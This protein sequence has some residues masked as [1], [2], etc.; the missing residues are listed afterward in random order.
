MKQK[1]PKIP[2]RYR[3]VLLA[4]L[5]GFVLVSGLYFVTWKMGQDDYCYTTHSTTSK[6]P[7]KLETAQDFFDQGNYDYDVG[8]CAKAAAGYSYAVSKNPKFAE[9][10]NNRAYTYMRMHNYEMALPDLDKAIELRPDYVNALRNRAD[11]LT[12]YLKGS[13]RSGVPDYDKVIAL[14]QSKG[15]SVCGHRAMAMHHK[16]VLFAFWNFLTKPAGSGC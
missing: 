10:Y 8:N 4:S 11:L 16:I 1:F 15:T 13:T 14:G 7:E 2:L 3:R 12:F 9:A 5:F 6:P